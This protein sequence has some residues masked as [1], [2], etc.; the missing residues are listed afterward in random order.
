MVL[1][2]DYIILRTKPIYQN[3]TRKNKMRILDLFTK[4]FERSRKRLITVLNTEDNDYPNSFYSAGRPKVYTQPVIDVVVD[5]WKHLGYPSS[6]ILKAQ[7]P[8]VITH[9]ETDFFRLSN[10]I[11]K[12]VLSASE[13]TLERMIKPYRDKLRPKGRSTTKSSK[14]PLRRKIPVRTEQWRINMPGYLEGDLVS[15]C[16]GKAS[17]G[18]FY[19]LNT[20]DIATQWFSARILTSKRDEESLAAMKSIEHYL[21]FDMKG[22]DT[23]NGSEFINERWVNEFASR[24]EFTRSRPYK[25]N[26][27]AHIEQKNWQNIRRYLA[28]GRFDN[29]RQFE[30]LDSLLRNELSD[31][32]NFFVPVQ[33]AIEKERIG[34]KTRTKRDAPKTPYQR[35]LES[36]DIPQENKDF[37]RKRFKKLHPFL[38]QK[39]IW[40]T[41]NKIYELVPPAAW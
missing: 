8:L 29:S 5:M 23:D 24:L 21:P 2:N 27:N 28:Y 11:R 15:H 1:T 34:T 38:L 30:L 17:D 35:V 37:L 3:A 39:K 10:G 12:K 14:H 18:H 41:L 19:T 25:K 33:K 32:L 4:T 31:F 7:I 26:D 9:Y 6:R 40:N 36:P 20:T 16:G 22:I 13:R